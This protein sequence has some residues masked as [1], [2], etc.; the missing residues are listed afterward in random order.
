MGHHLQHLALVRVAVEVRVAAAEIVVP[1][2]VLVVM[3][4][5]VWLLQLLAHR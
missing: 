4:V 1:A 3:V 2:Q 5:V